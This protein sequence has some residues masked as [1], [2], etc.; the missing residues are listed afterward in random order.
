M[1]FLDHLKCKQTMFFIDTE[2]STYAPTGLP[3]KEQ[4]G[5]SVV[6][7]LVALCSDSLPKISVSQ[8]CANLQLEDLQ[9]ILVQELG[10]NFLKSLELFRSPQ[11]NNIHRYLAKAIET[12]QLPVIIHLGWDDALELALQELGQLA[13]RDYYVFYNDSQLA[14]WNG[15]YD[16]PIIL[17]VRGSIRDTS[18]II[19]NLDQYQYG[20]GSHK[21]EL[22]SYL[23]RRYYSVFLGMDGVFP[24]LHHFILET[25]P[26]SCPGV[27]VIEQNLEVV[28]DIE[29]AIRLY[30]HQIE[31]QRKS[32]FV[33]WEELAR[34]SDCLLSL[35]ATP[36]QT[37]P[38]PSIFQNK[39]CQ[40]AEELGEWR[41]CQ[42][43][44]T[45]LERLGKHNT[46]ICYRQQALE[47]VK[48]Q[49]EYIQFP[50]IYRKIGVLYTKIRQIELA[51]D[52][53]SQSLGIAE[54]QHQ[55]DEVA[56]IHSVVGGLA[57][58][59]QETICEYQMAL[60]IANKQQNYL[61]SAQFCCLFADFYEQQQQ[62]I[63]A[64]EYCQKAVDYYKSLN[65]LVQTS[66]IYNQ[67]GRIFFYRKELS[68]AKEY[69]LQAQ[70]IAWRY[71]DIQT[72][73]R[74][75]TNLAIIT[76]QENDYFGAQRLYWRAGVIMERI[77][78]ATGAALV[79]R[80]LALLKYSA[81]DL[82]GT[83]KYLERCLAFSEQSHCAKEADQAQQCLRELDIHNRLVGDVVVQLA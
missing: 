76:Q 71:G 30:G 62:W 68:K 80:N 5:R 11:P 82:G 6:Q 25:L 72:V 12:R 48:R 14:N 15:T 27:L 67:M 20:L 51:K 28:Q 75:Y 26:C 55:F 16:K 79:Y 64:L 42:V 61:Q 31:I 73:A 21:I 7:H 44:A 60:D 47:I 32:Q 66:R 35:S 17:Y 38:D 81:N 74:V 37:S 41:R 23:L 29:R 56:L 69:Y 34:N 8:L 70:D 4:W 78:E 54:K 1:K 65:S 9:R 45:L 58:T 3:N 46:A 77:G 40:W 13:G 49:E 10:Q 63:L 59:P 39:I 36:T 50:Q 53:L 52:H 22:L 57:T 83:K 18:G 24:Y 19:A 2:I 43:I 33:F